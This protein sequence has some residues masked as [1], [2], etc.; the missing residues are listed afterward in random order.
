MKE[1]RKFDITMI[2]KQADAFYKKGDF[3]EAF[4]LYKQAAELGNP[5]AQYNLGYYYYKGILLKEKNY[6]E[7][8][9]WFE[10]AA[11]QGQPNA[12]YKLGKMYTEGLG[13]DPDK[14]KAIYWYNQA[15]EQGHWNALF[16]FIE[17]Y[18]KKEDVDEQYE[19]GLI[20]LFGTST[21]KKDYQVA[22]ELFEIAAAN[23]HARS[24]FYLG[25]ICYYG[26]C[27]K[28]NYDEA[29]E[30]YKK[31][32]EKKDTWSFFGINWLARKKNLNSVSFLLDITLKNSSDNKK[33]IAVPLELGISYFE[34]TSTEQDFHKAKH[35]FLDNAEH[36]NIVAEFYL[37]YLYY[38]GLIGDKDYGLAILWFGKAAMNGNQSAQYAVS[39]MLQ[40]GD[41]EIKED[42]EKAREW[43]IKALNQ[44]DI[45]INS[46]SKSVYQEIISWK[47]YLDEHI[48]K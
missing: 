39:K 48:K 29:F 6:S 43:Y 15:I 47:N 24:N 20:F 27:G 25:E 34:G 42:K 23:G 33:M 14:L 3:S 7:A 9:K 38:K 41:G 18:S 45:D 13:T 19:F 12:Q 28:P 10:F 21:V 46:F 1:K 36:G 16:D 17:Y 4:Q 35:I 11:I 5:R 37:G 32:T 2:I 8:L 31:G 22:K 40:S 30:W 44:G 26:K